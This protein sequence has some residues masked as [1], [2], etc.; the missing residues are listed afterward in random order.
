MRK[1]SLLLV[2]LDTG[3]PSIPPYGISQEAATTHNLAHPDVLVLGPSQRRSSYP[4]ALVIGPSQS[5][6]S[7]PDV[8]VLGPSQSRSSYPDALVIGPSQSR[9][10]HLDVLVLGPSQS[11]SY[12]YMSNTLSPPTPVRGHTNDEVTY[13][14]LRVVTSFFCGVCNM[15]G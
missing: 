13:R 3:F 7:H 5:R 8:L 9:S 12:V 15:K 14:D 10:S 2:L 11:R 6:S 1:C 4:D